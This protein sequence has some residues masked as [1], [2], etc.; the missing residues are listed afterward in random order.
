M[1]RA[2]RFL[3][4]L[5]QRHNGDDRVA[6]VTHGG[7]F[8]AVLRTLFGFATL[9]NEESENRIWLHAHNTSITRLDFSEG[10]VDLLYLNRLDHLPTELIT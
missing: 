4:E 5:Q 7:F 10:R 2:Q 3:D 9:D 8:V 1:E 6:I